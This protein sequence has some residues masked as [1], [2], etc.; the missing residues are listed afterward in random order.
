MEELP[1]PVEGQY[2]Y[3]VWRRVDSHP[4]WKEEH[5]EIHSIRKWVS[6]GKWSHFYPQGQSYQSWM[7]SARALPEGEEREALLEG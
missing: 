2:M 7:A 3:P 5:V 6:G 1:P 4:K